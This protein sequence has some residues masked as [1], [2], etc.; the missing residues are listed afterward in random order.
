MYCIYH[1]LSVYWSNLLQSTQCFNKSHQCLPDCLLRDQLNVHVMDELAGQLDQP[2]YPRANYWVHLAAEFQVPKDVIMKCQHSFERSPSKHLLEIKEGVDT[3]FSVQ[4]LKKGLKAIL[5][6]DL[7]QKVD[8]C[9]L[10]GKFMA[11]Y[12]L[13][14]RR[15]LVYSTEIFNLY[16]YTCIN[17]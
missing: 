16:C 12:P 3:S 14:I 6:N 8:N 9:H 1:L 17:N 7:V 2:V 10:A 4:E 13:L 11:F 15:E 5:R